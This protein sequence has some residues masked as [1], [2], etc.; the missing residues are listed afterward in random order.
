MTKDTLLLSLESDADLKQAATLLSAGKLVAIPTETVY[1][2]AASAHDDN[3][4]KGVFAAKNRPSDHPLILHIG[5]FSQLA[6]WVIDVPASAKLLAEHCWPGPLTMIFNKAPGVSGLITGGRD[7]IAIR[8]PDKTRLRQLLSVCGPVVAPSANLHK[9]IS[10]TC[11]QQVMDGLNGRIDAVLDGGDCHLGLESTIVDLTV[12]P[13][14]ILRAGPYYAEQLAAIM[15]ENVVLPSSHDVAVA[16]NMPAHYQPNTP[17]SLFTRQ[18][19]EANILKRECNGP[20]LA[21]IHMSELP[22]VRLN[23][24][25]IHSI[26]LSTQREKY[27]SQLYQALSQA[28]R[29]NC[30]EIWIE[31]PPYEWHEVIDRVSRAC[32]KA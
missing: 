26:K 8:M 18:A 16:G 21:I 3:A 2:L 24:A 14:R 12:L 29:M 13:V 20:T 27:A 5:Q 1:G 32:F 22:L 15:G 25:S 11:A 9:K 23:N 17:A 7:T 4:I 10:P 28:D 30:D 31:Q 19:L 6:D